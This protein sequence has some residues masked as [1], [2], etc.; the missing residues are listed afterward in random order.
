MGPVS[1]GTYLWR[2]ICMR[3]QPGSWHKWTDLETQC[4]IRCP[5]LSVVRC[6]DQRRQLVKTRFRG[7]DA[8]QSRKW[9]DQRIYLIQRGFHREPLWEVGRSMRSS[10]PIIEK[11]HRYLRH[12]CHCSIQFYHCLRFRPD[13]L[14]MHR[15]EF[16]LDR[17]V[18]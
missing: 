1:A 10:C 18:R 15:L 12:T 2:A 7:N 8:F 3:G 6:V 4:Q 13:R 11:K 14:T 9:A 5:Q 17:G 16:Q